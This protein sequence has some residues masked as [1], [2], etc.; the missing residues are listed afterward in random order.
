MTPIIENLV[1]GILP[2]DGNEARKIRI[3]APQYKL[4]EGNLYKK[5]F[6]SP[7]LRCVGPKQ[8][9]T[10]IFEIHEG[11][12]GLHVGPRS[13]ATKALRLGYFWPTMHRDGTTLLQDCEACQAKQ[14]KLGGVSR[15]DGPTWEGP[16]KID[17]VIGNGAYKLS[18]IDDKPVSR[19]WNATNLRKFYC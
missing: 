19:T 10:I 7:W 2:E 4:M 18:T 14:C 12:C 3:K 11:I 13:V 1:S 9:E 5:A 17:A 16:Y 8:A 6:L 15:K